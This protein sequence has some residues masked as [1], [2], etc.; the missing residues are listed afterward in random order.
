M[1]KSSTQSTTTQ[2]SQTQPWQAAQPLLKDVIGALS[3]QSTAVTPEQATA[4]SQLQTAAN[5][6]PSFN[7]A[8]SINAML[9]LNTSPQIGMLSDAYGNLTNSLS[10]LTDPAN[11]NPMNTPGLADSLKTMTNDITNQVKSVYA[12]SG[13]D[14]SGAGSF[15][16]SLGR[17]LTQGIAPVLTSQY[18]ANVGNLENA[19]GALENAGVTTAGQTTAQEQAPLAADA[20]ALGLIPQQA[21]DTMT[22]ASTALTA[23]NTAY[24]LPYGNINALLQPA[25]ILG[26]MGGQSSGTSTTSTPQSTMGNIMGGMMGGVGMLSQMGAFGPAGWLLASDERV[27]DNVEEVGKLHDGK[28]K[29][30]RF[31]YKDEPGATRIGLL[32]QDVAEHEPDAVHQTPIGMLM[33][34]HRRATDRAAS[35]RRAA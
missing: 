22:P 29:V 24:Q 13:R 1:S 5:T 16:Q 6:I 23:A 3:G 2:S 27:K 21:T 26:G 18:N 14:P 30:Y 10:P 32:A 7:T 4:S 28:T 34:D 31:N 15:A 25:A 19:A 9:G 12:G 11:L 17:G 33:V 8:D 35:M 20:T